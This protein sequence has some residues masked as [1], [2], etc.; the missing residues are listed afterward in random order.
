[1][2]TATGRYCRPAKT[3]LG[4]KKTDGEG[5]LSTQTVISAS[6]SYG[7]VY[8]AD[9]DAD[10]DPDAVTAS[11]KG[12]RIVWFSNDIEMGRGFSN[13]QPIVRRLAEK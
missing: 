12:N 8:T 5:T 1:M 13:A 10:E 6:G 7:T 2:E 3:W 11:Q 4:T 9:L